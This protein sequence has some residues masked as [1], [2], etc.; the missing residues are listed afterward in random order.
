MSYL[1]TVL[2]LLTLPKLQEITLEYVLGASD[3]SID[4][5]LSLGSTMAEHVPTLQAVRVVR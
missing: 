5:A 4:Q 1:E 2:R 3:F